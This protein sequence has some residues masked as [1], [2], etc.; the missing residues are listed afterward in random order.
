M[1]VKLKVDFIVS[2]NVNSNSC[3]ALRVEK[4][5]VDAHG[6]RKV[7]LMTNKTLA[8]IRRCLRWIGRDSVLAAAV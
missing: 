4:I 8:L 1:I 2:T 3:R 6:I 5:N 7:S